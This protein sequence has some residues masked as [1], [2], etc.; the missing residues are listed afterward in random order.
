[1]YR[2][3]LPAIFSQLRNAGLVLDIVGEP[4]PEPAGET[5]NPEVLHILQTMPVFLFIRAV[6]APTLLSEGLAE[7]P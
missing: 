1:M 4:Q 7:A 5:S 2:R 6:R 3:P